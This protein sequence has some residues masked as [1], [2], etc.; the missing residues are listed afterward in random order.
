[1]SVKG[2]QRRLD[3]GTRA[4]LILDQALR[5]FAERHYSVVTVRDIALACGIQN[6]LIYYYFD[7]KDH[8]LRT[9]LTHAIRKIRQTY[10]V[11]P[12]HSS[13]PARDLMEWLRAQVPM[14]SM[15]KSL[16]KVMADY[17]ASSQQD[18]SMDEMIK[19]FY[20]GEQALL[21]HYLQR[22]TESGRC[23]PFDIP[24]TARLISLQIDGI[25]FSATSRNDNRIGQDIEVLCEVIALLTVT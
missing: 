4:E 8:L 10:A 20:E 6:G 17:S 2:V 1:L 12:E 14:T 18:A 22:M 9:V 11:I 24:K 5:L 13:E 25:F 21:E 16:T 23:I 15:L 7:N 3:P 19:D